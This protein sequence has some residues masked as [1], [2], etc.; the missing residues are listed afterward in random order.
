MRQLEVA[1]ELAE[2]FAIGWMEDGVRSLR[3]RRN[4]VKYGK[5]RSRSGLQVGGWESELGSKY[6]R[7]RPSFDL[8]K[9]V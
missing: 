7:R 1:S 5:S 9:V 2:K 3:R 4:V 8:C 6:R